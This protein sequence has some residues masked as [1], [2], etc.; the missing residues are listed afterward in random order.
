[1]LL[2]ITNLT[3]E[4]LEIDYPFNRTLAAAGDPG[5]DLQ[6]G[7]GIDDLVF[8]ELQG[9][10]AYKRLNLLRQQGKVTLALAALA[11]DT[12]ILEAANTLD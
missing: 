10:P 6:L 4:P 11:T 8:G 9:N 5:D 3:A 12:S 2:T 1:M 7:V